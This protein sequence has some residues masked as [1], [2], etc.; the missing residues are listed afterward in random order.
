MLYHW[1]YQRRFNET[2]HSLDQTARGA[3]PVYRP[4]SKS[5]APVLINAA[6]PLPAV[7]GAAVPAPVQ[8]TNNSK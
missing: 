6:T 2:A 8:I 5:N 3:W 7:A 4:A 1:L